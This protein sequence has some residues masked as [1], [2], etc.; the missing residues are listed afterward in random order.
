MGWRFSKCWMCLPLCKK[1]ATLSIELSEPNR[2]THID[3]IARVANI[4]I[5]QGGRR[6]GW[7][8]PA[9]VRCGGL[10]NH[11]QVTV[12]L[13]RRLIEAVVV[14]A[15]VMVNFTWKKVGWG[16]ARESR[17]NERLGPLLKRGARRH[18]SISKRTSTHVS[19]GH[20]GSYYRLPE[21]NRALSARGRL[22]TGSSEFTRES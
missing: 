8:I 9:M 4:W 13:E 18:Q 22:Q 15:Q 19:F 6:V 11:R 17:F 10:L 21:L 12:K 2:L 1:V 7:R 3:K 14:Q 5:I 20:P 16:K